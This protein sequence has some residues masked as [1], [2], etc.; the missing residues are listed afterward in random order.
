MNRARIDRLDRAVEEGLVLRGMWTARG[1][2]GREGACLLATLAPETASGNAGLCPAEVM[3]EWLARLTP[4]IDD[5]GSLAEWSGMV[6]RY[7]AVAA[8]WYVLTLGDWRQLDYVVRAIIV[9]EAVSHSREASVL[10]VCEWAAALC[11]RAGR[12]ERVEEGEW[13]ATVVT[14][15]AVRANRMLAD[16]EWAAT[17]AARCA[18]QAD[19]SAMKLAEAAEWALGSVVSWS[20][21]AL[22]QALAQAADRITDHI[23]SAIE[24]RCTAREAT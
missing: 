3:P 8:R 1:E 9:R 11:D 12:G 5:S 18:A 22:A 2:D 20:M 16:A 6:R 17:A 19:P 10:V 14:V 21:Q 15:A 23:L 4:W 24:A 13:A 7:A